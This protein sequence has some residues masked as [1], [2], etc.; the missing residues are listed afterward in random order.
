VPSLSPKCSEWIAKGVWGQKN[1]S[2][3]A[4]G[5]SWLDCFASFF[6][7]TQSIST[8]SPEQSRWYMNCYSSR[9]KS[10]LLEPRLTLNSTHYPITEDPELL[11][12]SFSPPKCYHIT[13]SLVWC[14]DWILL[15]KHYRLSWATVPSSLAK[16]QLRR[17]TPWP[18]CLCST[19]L[20]HKH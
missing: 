19:L 6:E 8:T 12:L 9:L 14:Q 15:A 3:N 5:F 4:I 18:L 20:T 10:R 2:N 16:H 1:H 17:K 7:C 13:P 11:I